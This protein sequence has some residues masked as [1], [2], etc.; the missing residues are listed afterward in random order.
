MKTI[1]PE[2]ETLNRWSAIILDAAI[3]VHKELGPGLLESVY[4]HCMIKE[5]QI[6]ELQVL[7]MIPVRLY[8]K[9]EPLNKD[10][11]KVC[12]R[13]VIIPGKA[14]GMRSFD[15]CDVTS[16]KMSRLEICGTP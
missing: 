2:V 15:R 5:L 16:T 9:G 3:S 13:I 6:R 14:H 12:K 10:Y 11:I 8:Y 1:R 7:T 4:Q